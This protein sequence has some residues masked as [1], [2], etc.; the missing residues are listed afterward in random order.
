V[1]ARRASASG[2]AV[3]ATWA[4][5]GVAAAGEVR[6]AGVQEAGELEAGGFHPGVYV[7]SVVFGQSAAF[8]GPSHELGTGMNLGIRAAFE[9]ANRNNPVFGRQLKLRWLDDGYEPEAA[10]ANSRTLID[11]GVFALIGAVGTPTSNAAE[12]VAGAASVPYIAPFTGAEFL[13]VDRDH[14]VNLRASYF[15]ETEE[16]VER[17]TSDLGTRRIAILY[18]EDSYGDAGLQG[19]LGALERRGMELVS[20]GTY[21]R[22]TVAVKRAL[23]AIREGNP[24]AVIIVGSYAAAAEF[25]LWAREL[26]MNSVF[27]NLSFVGSN[28]LRQELGA[29]GEGVIVTQV[30]P[31]PLDTS[32]AVVR[33]YHAALRAVD[34][35]AEPGF[36]SLEGYLAGRFTVEVLRR[37]GVSPTRTSFL[38]ATRRGPIDLGG[39]VV[40]YGQGDN[41]GSDRVYMTEIRGGRFV[42]LTRLSR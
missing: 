29:E 35:G 36:V 15:Q 22:N 31:F 10:V 28:A 17:L 13:R 12:A 34:P 4:A 27:L 3:V 23:L 26:G 33:D 2:A 38:E 30:V 16:M 1:T 18:Q 19:V 39:F 7:D 11:E 21:T 40:E 42:S 25:I 8:T 9:E 14:V 20:S 6:G 5:A 37:V 41:Q 32:L 24:Q